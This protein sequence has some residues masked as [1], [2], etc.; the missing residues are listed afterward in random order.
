MI[1]DLKGRVTLCGTKLKFFMS[2]EQNGSFDFTPLR[3]M[4]SP[5]CLSLKYMYRL[6]LSQDVMLQKYFGGWM[7]TAYIKRH[8][9]QRLIFIVQ[10]AEVFFCVVFFFPDLWLCSLISFQLWKVQSLIHW[11]CSFF[12]CFLL[13]IQVLYKRSLICFTFNGLLNGSCLK[14]K[15]IFG[16][17]KRE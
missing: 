15:I 12:G 4:L 10:I 7:K 17:Q 5:S 6:L 11:I 1:N 14:Q 9:L 2:E 16:K 13:E 8:Y 3:G